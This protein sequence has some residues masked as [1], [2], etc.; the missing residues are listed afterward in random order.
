MEQ[1]DQT[2]K[3]FL[4][5][6][7]LQSFQQ[8]LQQTARIRITATFLTSYVTLDKLFNQSLVNSLT[9]KMGM[10][11]S[12]MQGYIRISYTFSKRYGGL[13]LANVYFLLEIS[14]V[15][16]NIKCIYCFYQIS[17]IYFSL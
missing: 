3:S 5:G 13:L 6:D 16:L 4:L 11:A 9:Y 1:G 14:I 12:A 2:F 8:G 10:V 17:D 7:A 15:G